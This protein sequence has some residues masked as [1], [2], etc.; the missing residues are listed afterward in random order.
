[1]QRKKA[2]VLSWDHPQLVTNN[3]CNL[4]QSSLEGY[5][6][7]VNFISVSKPLQQQFQNIDLNSV[8]LVFCVGHEP[9]TINIDG[10]IIYD[11][12]NCPFYVY[13][14]DTPIY[15][16]RNPLLIKFYDDA[17]HND[18]LHLVFAEQSYIDLY[19]SIRD[20]P[21]IDFIPFAAF[22]EIS[23]NTIE[24]QDKVLVIGGL[25]T[26]LH[27]HGSTLE[28]TFLSK[29]PY[30]ITT[31]TRKKIIDSLLSD[32]F[33]GNVS[34]VIINALQL[35]PSEILNPD[36]ISLSCSVDSFLK[37]DNRIKA[38]TSLNNFPTDFYGP[39]W[40]DKFGHI[41]SFSFKGEITHY[42]IS[43]IIKSY[44]VVLNF[45]PNWEH[46]VH[47]RVFTTLAAG[48]NLITNH[49]K[50]LNELNN[51]SNIYRYYIN[52]PNIEE[53]AVK[54]CSNTQSVNKDFVL[55]NHSW[56]ERILRLLEKLP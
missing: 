35:D 5:N 4:I 16:F 19:E 46:G 12:F 53:L 45:D 9:L 54:A 36:F 44:K 14:L 17:K 39:G 3:F 42:E 52:D 28:D 40:K 55:L 47:D 32:K 13:C 50:Y 6:L 33:L 30:A 31:S 11:F 51:D 1:M 15:N 18:N 37:L 8:S 23:S 26:Q 48:S 21:T 20:C 34:N 49:N 2:L 10:K 38:I 29:D 43:K 7:E 56:N 41:P 25:G 24:K 27:S 22:P